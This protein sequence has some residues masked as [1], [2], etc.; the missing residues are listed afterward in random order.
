MTSHTD[1]RRDR[2]PPEVRES[3]PCDVG[4]AHLEPFG[5]VVEWREAQIVEKDTD[6]QD[7]VVQIAPSRSA[8]SAANR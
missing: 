1:W 7:L 4:A 6:V 3:L 2:L 5:S 8:M